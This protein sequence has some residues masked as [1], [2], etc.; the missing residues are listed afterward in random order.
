MSLQGFGDLSMLQWSL[1]QTVLQGGNS[2]FLAGLC[3]FT[4][5]KMVW[6]STIYNQC[7]KTLLTSNAFS[8]GAESGF[9]VSTQATLDFASLAFSP[10]NQNT[11]KS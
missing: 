11:A 4:Q 1:R 3:R 8:I 10:W 9:E 6:N 2:D 7:T 5:A